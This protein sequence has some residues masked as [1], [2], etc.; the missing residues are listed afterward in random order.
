MTP[1]LLFPQKDA[2]E[3][4]H[5]LQAFQAVKRLCNAAAGAGHNNSLSGSSVTCVTLCC[6]HFQKGATNMCT[7]TA[8]MGHFKQTNTQSYSGAHHY[9]P[10]NY[11]TATQGPPIQAT[12]LWYTSNPCP[13]R[14]SSFKVDSSPKG[15]EKKEGVVLQGVQLQHQR[16][17]SSQLTR[18]RS[19][20]SRFPRQTVYT[21]N[22]LVYLQVPQCAG[23]MARDGAARAHTPH[24]DGSSENSFTMPQSHQRHSDRDTGSRW[25]SEGRG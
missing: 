25:L 17:S 12:R 7:C 19:P 20:Q 24:A 18:R 4:M 13:A 3:P 5:V 9:Q 11:C 2:A 15:R 21:T 10:T 23:G 16:A 14:Q 6:C 1:A 8:A 22:T